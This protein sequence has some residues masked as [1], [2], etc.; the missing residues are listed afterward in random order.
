MVDAAERRETTR[1]HNLVV[2][3]EFLGAIRSLADVDG[4]VPVPWLEVCLP[5]IRRL[6]DVGIH[7]DHERPGA[8]AI[9]ISPP[10]P[11]DDATIQQGA[12]ARWNFRGPCAQYA[13][14]ERWPRV[15][16]A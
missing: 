1:Q 9:H 2:D 16:G 12:I 13:P 10:Y 15:E 11:V 14:R 6:H 3:D 8:G 5:E 7:V 4:A